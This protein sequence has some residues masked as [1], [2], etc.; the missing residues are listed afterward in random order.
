MHPENYLVSFAHR[1]VFEI[2]DKFYDMLLKITVNNTIYPTT[3]QQA[4]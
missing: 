3:Q 1:K 4:H 2:A